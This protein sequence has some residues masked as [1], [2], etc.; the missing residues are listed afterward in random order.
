MSETLADGSRLRGTA[1]RSPM[2]LPV[3]VGVLFQL[4]AQRPLCVPL[5][6]EPP[7]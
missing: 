6:Q 1:Q 7:T 2:L 5:P 3:V 4:E